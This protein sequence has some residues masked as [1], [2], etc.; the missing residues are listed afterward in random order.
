MYT[1]GSWLQ[2]LK[3]LLVLGG[4]GAWWRRY[5]SDNPGCSLAYTSSISSAET[6]RVACI[7]GWFIGTMCTLCSYGTISA[8]ASTVLFARHVEVQR[9][10][11]DCAFY[12]WT[13]EGC[14]LFSSRAG[15]TTSIMIKLMDIQASSFDLVA[16]LAADRRPW[17]RPPITVHGYGYFLPWRSFAAAPMCRTIQQQQM[18]S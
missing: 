6:P 7:T 1:D 14:L 8:Q 10:I 17:Q 11:H 4:A 9:T 18:D 16:E 2:P 15:T 5:I 3:Q 13:T 12:L